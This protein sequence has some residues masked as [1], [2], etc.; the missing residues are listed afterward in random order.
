MATSWHGILRTYISFLKIRVFLW[1]KRKEKRKENK[2][3]KNNKN[4]KKEVGRK[5]ERC[6]KQKRYSI[7]TTAYNN[8]AVSLLIAVL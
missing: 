2:N 6:S 7:I 4:I 3:N 5:K 1:E 8:N